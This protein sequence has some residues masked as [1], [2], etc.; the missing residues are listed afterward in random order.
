VRPPPPPAPVAV[1]PPPPPID[2]PATEP[3][4]GAGYVR[5]PQPVYPLMSRRMREQ[6][7]VVLRVFVTAQGDPREI[8]L[9]KGSGFARLDRA[10]QEAVHRWK[11]IPA[12]RGNRPVDAWVNV[13]IEFRLE[14]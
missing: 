6:G 11:F 1:A 13:P 4:W 3:L 2:E 5:N 10:A 14:G 12:K 8:Q 9:K 7:E